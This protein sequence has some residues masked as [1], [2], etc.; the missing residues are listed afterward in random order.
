MCAS[1]TWSDI[2]ELVT[3]TCPEGRHDTSA[4]LLFSGTQFMACSAA[5]GDEELAMDI[6]M[7][8][9][10]VFETHGNQELRGRIL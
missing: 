4:T 9:G 6:S 3:L 10:I 8:F 7:P 1:K 5:S 2:L